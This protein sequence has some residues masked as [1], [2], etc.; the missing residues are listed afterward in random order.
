MSRLPIAACMLALLGGAAAAGEDCPGHS[1]ALGT[2][3]VWNVTVAASGGELC[4]DADANGSVTV[5]DGVQTLRAAAALPTVCAPARCDVDG[6]G[7]VS[8]SDGVNVLRGAAGLSFPSD[9]PG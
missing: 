6:N 3:R 9:C 5:T 7:T 1:G 4:G 8:V 2:S